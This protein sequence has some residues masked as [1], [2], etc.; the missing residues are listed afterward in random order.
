MVAGLVLFLRFALELVI[1]E[2]GLW[3][4]IGAVCGYALSWA[5]PGRMP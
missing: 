3:W 4:I 2:P 1:G 5:T